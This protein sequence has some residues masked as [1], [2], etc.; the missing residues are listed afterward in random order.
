[1]KFRKPFLIILLLSLTVSAG[2]SQTVNYP[3]PPGEL[4]P[5]QGKPGKITKYNH[6]N[7]LDIRNDEDGSHRQAMGNYWE[8]SFNYDSVFR[9]KRKFKSFIEDQIIEKQG[10][11]LFQDTLQVQFVIPAEGGNIWGRLILSSDK[12]YRLRLIREVPFRNKIVFDTKPV[13]EFGQF[14]TPVNLPPRINYLPNSIIA[15]VQQSKF[16]H[17]E[18]TWNLKDTLYRQ[19]VMG[20]YWD[21]KIEVRNQQ[22]EVDRFVSSVEV[23]ESYYRACVAAGGKVLKSR[24]K[25]LLFIL[26]LDEST[27]WCRVTVSLDGI[28]FVRTVLQTDADRTVPEKMITVVPP[29]A[30]STQIGP[31]R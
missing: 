8:I 16:D 17:Q 9:Q 6:F 7:Y 15:R 13:A 4:K 28:Y 1:M 11:L 29:V 23:L 19:K 2:F 30:D 5:Y 31:E 25:E 27:L 10:S 22:G 3:D 21:M 20:P 14:I 12:V 24:P 18:F 26:P